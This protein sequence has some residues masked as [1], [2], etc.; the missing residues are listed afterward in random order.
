MPISRQMLLFAKN[1][2]KYPK[3]LGSVV[4]SSPFLVNHLLSFI[5]WEQARVIVEYG[6][7]VGTI[8]GEILKRMRADA[9]LTAQFAIDGCEWCMVLPRTCALSSPTCNCNTPTTSSLAFHTPPCP[10]LR[11]ATSSRNRGTCFV[12]KGPW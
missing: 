6:P 1:F 10:I 11:V 9:V 7:G 12:P 8:T 3:L 4:P 2:V 5:N